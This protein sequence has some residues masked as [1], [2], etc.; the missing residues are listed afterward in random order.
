MRGAL[1]VGALLAV[2]LGGCASAPEA[3]T[4]DWADASGYP[5]LRDVPRGGT[6]ATTDQRHWSAVEADLLAARARLQANP[7]SQDTG[8]V[9]DPQQFLDEARR[10]VE[11]T[12]SSHNPY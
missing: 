5:S 12:R 1:V 7:R 3:N 2:G 10:E 11:E 6:S 9:E 4:P 8:P